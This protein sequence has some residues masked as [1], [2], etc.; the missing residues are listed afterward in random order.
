M[1]HLLLGPT[2]GTALV[3]NLGGLEVRSEGEAPDALLGLPS[4]C[5]V[6]LMMHT[7][8]LFIEEIEHFDVWLMFHLGHALLDRDGNYLV[9][10]EAT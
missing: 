6:I 10:P 3:D 9:E 8:L 7:S 1:P 4:P 2:A 5:V